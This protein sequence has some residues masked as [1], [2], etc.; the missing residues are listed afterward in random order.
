[1]PKNKRT[2]FNKPALN[3]EEQLDLL[4][5][6][7]LIIP[8]PA[9]AL[10]YL[11]FIG[12]YRLSGYCLFYQEKPS[13]IFRPGTTFDMV[14]D[15]YIFDRQLRMLVMD[16]MERIE[17]AVRAC[18]TNTLSE[19]YG[20]HWYLDED[21]F[22][23][24]YNHEELIRK[25]KFETGLPNDS[26]G[27]V[28]IRKQEVFLKHYYQN[29]HSPELPPAWMVAEVMPLGVWSKIFRYLKLRDDQKKICSPFGIHYRVMES[30]LHCLT[31]LRNLCAHHSR[32][33]N[34]RFSI[35]PKIM[36]KYKKELT[37]NT[38]F[39]AQAAMLHIFMYVIADGSKWQQRLAM[40]LEKYDT[41]PLTAMGFP[42]DWRNAPFWKFNN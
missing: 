20:P 24:Q 12:Y 8:K 19:K 29:Y 32:L 31:Y 21:L 34:R 38:Q 2:R 3:L 42:K 41:I 26:S 22:A 36:K 6:R 1:M 10:H 40:L 33:W 28:N 11:K 15:L 23:V 9:R 37:P 25:I 27:R 7:N 18:I 16:A 35:T 13:H 39:Y 17:V 5:S 30:W 14:L 4:R